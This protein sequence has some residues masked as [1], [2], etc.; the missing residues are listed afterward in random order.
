MASYQRSGSGVRRPFGSVNANTLGA[1]FSK[2]SGSAS[3]A[4]KSTSEKKSLLSRRGLIKSILA[5]KKSGKTDRSGNEEELSLESPSKKARIHEMSSGDNDAIFRR[6]AY[7][8]E[9]DANTFWSDEMEEMLSIK[10]ARPVTES[11][12]DD[13]LDVQVGDLEERDGDFRE[14]VR[15]ALIKEIDVYDTSSSEREETLN[16]E[17]LEEHETD[18]FQLNMESPTKK[19]GVQENYCSDI[20]RPSHYLKDA[21]S[22]NFWTQEMKEM[23]SLKPSR[24]IIE[25]DE[26]ETSL[27]GQVGGSNE[28]VDVDFYEQVRSA[29]VRELSVDDTSSAEHTMPLSRGHLKE[30]MNIMEF[31]LDSAHRH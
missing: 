13:S 27:D 7:L 21:D 6:S 20:F 30:H 25:S 5:T 17:R 19:A 8:S 18:G 22:K 10:L 1:G 2:S 24:P 12:D 4:V 15:D 16:N 28:L 23:L 31:R 26:D 29:L 3:G 11:R 9:D 14:Q